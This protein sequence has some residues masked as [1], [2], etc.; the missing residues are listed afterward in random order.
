M[1]MET[2]VSEK[3]IDMLMK[4]VND[5]EFH[6][7]C[8]S[9]KINE[10]SAPG[11]LIKKFPSKKEYIIR[12]IISETDPINADEIHLGNYEQKN[13]IINVIRSFDVISDGRTE[14]RLRKHAIIYGDTGVGKTSF[15]KMLRKYYEVI[16]I[17]A[18]NTRTFDAIAEEVQGISRI[19]S[20][21]GKERI[22]FFDEVDSMAKSGYDFVYNII[23]PSKNNIEASFARI[24][25]EEPSASDKKA[26][27]EMKVALSMR[28]RYTIILAC[29][30]ISKVP[31]RIKKNDR[32]RAF[33]FDPP[34]TFEIE[35]LLE[36]YANKYW[37]D[38]SP[39]VSEKLHKSAIQ[40]KKIASECH[41]DVRLAKSM[42]VAGEAYAEEKQLKPIDI[43]YMIFT[44]DEREKVYDALVEMPFSFTTILAYIAANVMKYYDRMSDIRQAFRIISDLDPIK[45]AASREMICSSIAFGI[46]V[47]KYKE[48]SPI[49]PERKKEKMDTNVN[50]D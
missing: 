6:N 11:L 25:K 36:L 50:Q 37:G 34:E 23:A 2:T 28:S 39:K 32:V 4:F 31:D 35:A 24:K 26:F 12:R 27:H 41:G 33:I 5:G 40:I 9:L 18:S 19:G 3:S 38:A 44:N 7:G 15:L 17:N 1:A 29:N 42:L 48:S 21:L 46:P 16:E 45:F 10:I 22:I 8:S 30:E 13:E 20:L 43:T 14:Y 47:S 49:Y